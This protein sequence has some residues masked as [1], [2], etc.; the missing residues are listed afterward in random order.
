MSQATSRQGRLPDSSSASC[1]A[2]RAAGGA[3]A[4]GLSF[5][6]IVVILTTPSR[7]HLGWMGAAIRPVVT[8]FGDAF[9]IQSFR[10]HE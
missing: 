10:V 3:A 4:S 7:P 6:T 9:A 2:S 8:G 1:A 5:A